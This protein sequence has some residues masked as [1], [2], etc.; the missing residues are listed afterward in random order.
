MIWEKCRIILILQ[1]EIDES[2]ELPEYPDYV[3]PE[4]GKGG[5]VE[6]G[7]EDVSSSNS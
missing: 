5:L 7:K 3:I 6:A 4:P 1:T 2:E